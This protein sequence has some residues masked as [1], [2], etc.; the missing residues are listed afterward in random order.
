MGLIGASEERGPPYVIEYVIY[1]ESSTA[2][3]DRPLSNLQNGHRPSDHAAGAD[4]SAAYLARHNSRA[5]QANSIPLTLKE[6]KGKEINRIKAKAKLQKWELDQMAKKHDA[7]Q[8]KKND[9]AGIEV[10]RKFMNYI[11]FGIS[12]LL[13]LL[14][15]DFSKMKDSKGGFMVDEDEGRKEESEAIL[16][17]RERLQQLKKPFFDPGTEPCR[18]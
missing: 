5:S 14:T 10:A 6:L 11:E 7:E 16:K 12:L 2:K 17:K 3:F 15:G 4:N 8:K 18:R 1:R 13:A 9:G